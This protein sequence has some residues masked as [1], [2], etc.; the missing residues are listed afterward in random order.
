MKKEKNAV[1]EYKEIFVKL[2]RYQHHGANN[3]IALLS[4]YLRKKAEYMVTYID[5]VS[6]RSGVQSTSRI[7]TTNADIMKPVVVEMVR[8]DKGV[9][10]NSKDIDAA[11]DAFIRDYRNH[12]I[13]L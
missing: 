8:I 3:L 10:P 4:R 6:E 11:W 2:Y 1:D 12:K 5:L 7:T 9:K 13:T